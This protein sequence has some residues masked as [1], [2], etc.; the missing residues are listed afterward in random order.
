MTKKVGMYELGQILGQGSFAIVREVTHSTTKQQFAMKI[1]D[2][3]K[4]QRDDSIE[5]IKKE[6]SILMMADHKNIVKL[7]EV[8]ASRTK[9]YLVLEYI[10]GGELWDLIKDRGQIS[11]DEMR[12][13][14]RQIIEAINYCKKKNIAHRDLKPENILLDQHGCIKVS[15]FGL[16]SLYQDPNQIQNLLHTTCG[17]INYLAPEVIQNMGYDGHMADIWSLGV[18]LFFTISGRLPFEDENVAKLLEKIVSVEY[19][20]PKTFSKNLK[21]LIK[22]ILNSNPKKRFTLEQIKQHRWYSENISKEEKEEQQLEE[23]IKQTSQYQRE[24]SISSRSS[25]LQNC[26]SDLD[27]IIQDQQPAQLVTKQI[28]PI[29][30]MSLLT[31]NILNKMFDVKGKNEQKRLQN[32]YQY[33]PIT[34]DKPIE[35]IDQTL[36]K[37]F[38]ALTPK[39]TSYIFPKQQYQL[40]CWFKFKK[41]ECSLSCKIYKIKE[42]LYLLNFIRKQGSIDNFQQSLEKIQPFLKNIMI[43]KKQN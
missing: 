16:S 36:K 26:E 6:I 9:I 15:D 24:L 21:D 14:F 13:Y 38:E 42:Q 27:G 18:I 37:A 5:S 1:I 30:L 11:E 17:T 40:K 25:E 32:A 23:E 29:Q 19:T 22:N 31:S 3:D 4:V 8:L 35:E 28:S 39:E 20:M 7:V 33:T 2:K 34:S 10:R 43:Q 12:K 41:E